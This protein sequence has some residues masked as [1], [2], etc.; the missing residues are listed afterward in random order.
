MTN[1]PRP[2]RNE[3]REAARAK[4]REMREATKR[5]A[6]RKRTILITSIVAAVALAVTGVVLTIK[7]EVNNPVPTASSPANMIFDGGIKIGK[8]LKAI[9]NTTDQATTPNIIVYEDLQCPNCRDFE[10]PNAAQMRDWVSSGKYTVQIH[11]IAFLDGN[12]ANEYSSRAASAA[13]CVANGDPDRFFD[14]NSALYA[15][16]PQEGTSGPN[17]DELA[18]RAQAIGVNNKP[19]L[20][21]IKNSTYK[22]Y[23]LDYTRNTVFKRVVPGTDLKVDGTPYIILK[24]QHFTGNFTNPALFAQWVLSTATSK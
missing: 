10:Q 16:Q 7:S 19:V 1:A 2:T 12:S 23:V 18:A 3:Q 11:P 8:G 24:G 5:S 20:D 22:S 17:N 9:T 4:A 13:I 21:C 14:Y 6:S 15:N